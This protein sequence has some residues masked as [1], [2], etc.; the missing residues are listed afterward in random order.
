MGRVLVFSWMCLVLC[1]LSHQ[2]QAATPIRG[3]PVQLEGTVDLAPPLV[4][5]LDGD[6]RLEL[7]LASRDKIHGL[8]MDGSAV[9]GFPVSVGK[10]AVLQTG[11]SLGRF[12]AQEPELMTFGTS[13]G[14]IQVFELNGKSLP[15]FPYMAGKKAVGTPVFAEMGT[16]GAKVVLAALMDGR[17]IAIGPDGKAQPGFSLRIPATPST[18]PSWGSLAPGEPPLLFIGD[19]QGYLHALKGNL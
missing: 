16:G 19:E 3:F 9:E 8:E 6:G 14:A 18:S 7:L 1:G 11:L 17:I 15:G 10:N 2:S 4:A 13:D 12:A 5:D